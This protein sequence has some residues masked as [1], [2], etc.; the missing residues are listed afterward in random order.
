MSKQAAYF[1][2]LGMVYD[3]LPDKEY[4]NLMIKNGS[5]VDASRLLLVRKG[6]TTDLKVLVHSVKT[7]LPDFKIPED[8]LQASA[9]LV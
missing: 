1:L 4:A 2:L 6:K 8:V 7:L 3:L 9:S 5:D